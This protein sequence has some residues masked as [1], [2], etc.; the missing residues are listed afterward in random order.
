MHRLPR[1]LGT[2]SVGGSIESIEGRV[3]GKSSKSGPRSPSGADVAVGQRMR[4]E[5]LAKGMSQTEL[6]NAAGVSFQQMQK[7][8]N[9]LNRVGAGRLMQIAEKLGVPVTAFFASTSAATGREE[10]VA[11][12]LVG[13]AR[14]VRL[15]K[16]FNRIENPELQSAI[17]RLVEDACHT[18]ASRTK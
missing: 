17:V 12:E 2:A 7:Y 10:R 16:A 3:M 5:R 6:A 1:R 13:S 14:A 8:E 11:L 4:I 9:G 18:A 15:L